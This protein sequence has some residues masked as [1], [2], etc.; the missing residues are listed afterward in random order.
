MERGCKS[1]VLVKTITPYYSPRHEFLLKAAIRLCFAITVAKAV[2]IK[3]KPYYQQS[4]HP[5]KGNKY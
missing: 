4:L 2:F 3:D 5:W 1:R